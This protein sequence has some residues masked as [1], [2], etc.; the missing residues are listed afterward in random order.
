MVERPKVTRYSSPCEIIMSTAGHRTYQSLRQSP[1]ACKTLK[2][3]C[4]D[5]RHCT[6]RQGHE[7]SSTSWRKVDILEYGAE[8]P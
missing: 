1:R 6:C 8:T 4:W 3:T 5:K 2:T 7:G